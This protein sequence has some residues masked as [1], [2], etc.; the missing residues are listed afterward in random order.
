MDMT[1][2]EGNI[3]RQ[4]LLFSLPLLAGNFFQQCYNTVDSIVLG[5]FVGRSALAA[6]GTTSTLINLLLGFFVGVSSGATVI[7]SQFF[8]AGDAKNV[9]KAVH[10]SMALA[11]AGGLAI[12]VLGL[13]TA[14]PSLV[15]L[16]VPQEIMGD[17]LTYVNVYYCGII[18]S[19]IYNVGT[20][21]L[22]AIGDSRMP[23]YVLMVCCLVNIVLDLLFVLAFHWGVF[24]VAIA[25]VLSQVVSAVLIMVRLMLTRE[26]YR[27]E[28]R[29]IRFDRG[30]L[31]NVIRIGLPA[32]LQ[33]VLYSVSNLV[34]QASINSFGT[35]AIA[36]WAAIGKIDGFIWMVMSAFGIAITTFVGQNV[37]A[38]NWDRAKQGI[39]TAMAMATVITL[40]ILVPLMIFAG[41]L[42]S[43][44]NQE[45]E[46]IGYGVY[47]IRLISPF[48][49]LANF[50]QIYAGALRGAGDAKMPMFIM[51][52]SFVLSSGYYDAYYKK[53][54]QVRTLIMDDF[55]NV[56]D[57]CDVLLTPT[58]AK[59]AFGIGE[60]TGNPLEM[61]LTDI[62]TVPVNIA[63]IP[64][65]SIPCGFDS[66][67]MPIGMQL[68]G[69]VL[70]EEKI[71]QAAYAF[72]R[73]T[74]FKD[75]KP[76]LV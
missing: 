58:T 53:A 5:N 33:S 42:C 6:V 24:G 39:R 26:S 16:G 21:I 49:L 3:F 31:R 48:Y 30:I 4:L 20:G 23:L 61:Y 11:L 45:T 55:K 2:T 74:A 76:K 68:L 50:N 54:M 72:E 38:G 69:P 52:G 62:Y 43:L 29:K 22:R 12:M 46:V 63:G 44:F 32:G 17:A 10:T 28:I 15:M 9:S 1:M 37:G 13:L 56:F 8:G 66:D 18:A 65:I 41:P 51:L 47:F 75:Q 60:K 36:S 19:M 64:G 67:G 57:S 40:I 73:E 70:S 7:I 71:L 35:D 27:V 59:T 34:V 25:T 14:R